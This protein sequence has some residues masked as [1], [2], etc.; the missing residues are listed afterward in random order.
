MS[1]RME[2][3]DTN[4]QRIF[5]AILLKEADLPPDVLVTVSRVETAANLVS[6]KIWLYINPDG[7]AEEV[8]ALLKPQMYDLQGALNRALD[9]HPLPRISLLI[10]Y[11]AQHADHIERTIRRLKDS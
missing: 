2:K 1:R 4:I 3:I 11:G 8:I 6:A 5:A 7:R 10:D 9:L